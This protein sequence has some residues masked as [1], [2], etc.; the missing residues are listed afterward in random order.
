MSQDFKFK[1]D[2]MRENIPHGSGDGDGSPH[3]EKYENAGNGR[4]VAFAW[5]D[6]RCQFLNYSY[7]ISGEFSPVEQG[8]TLVFTTHTVVL[9]G[10]RLQALFKELMDHIPKV[11]T[12]AET[13][14]NSILEPEQ[15]A[16]NDILVT[17]QA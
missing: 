14:Y 8:I 9:K 11:I 5:P 1:F 17:K 3:A 16:V 13:R 15:Y 6:G 10:V 2:Q 12:C 7:L 4:S